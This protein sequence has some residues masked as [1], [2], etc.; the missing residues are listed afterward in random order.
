MWDGP[1][2]TPKQGHIGPRIKNSASH[3]PQYVDKEATQEKVDEYD[4]T[5][6]TICSLLAKELVDD[7]WQKAARK[8]RRGQWCP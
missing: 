1:K 8:R 5:R 6:K 2:R 3:Q 4:D 7:E